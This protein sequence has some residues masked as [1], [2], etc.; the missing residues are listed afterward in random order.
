VVG[1]VRAWLAGNAELPRELILHTLVAVRL[2]C[3]PRRC[4]YAPLYATANGAEAALRQSEE[5]MRLVANNVP[6]IDLVRRPRPALPLQQ[7]HVRRWFGIPHESMQGRT[8][9]EVFGDEA[10]GRMRADIERVPRGASVEFEF[11]SGEGGR[12]ARCRWPA[13]RTSDGERRGARLL[14]AGDDVTALKRAQEDLRYAALQL[15]HDARRLEF[16]AHHD[17]LTGLP[18]RA[19][20]AERAREAVAHARRHGKTARFLFL[21]LDNF[22]RSTTRSAT[23]WATACSRTIASRLRASVRGDDFV[24]RIGGDEFCVLLQ[25]IADPREAA[26]VRRSWCTSSPSPTA[27]ASTSSPRREHRHRLRAAG[28]RGRGDAHAPRRHGHVPRQGA[29]PQRLPVLLADPQQDALG[30]LGHGSG[31]AAPGRCRAASCSSLTSRASTS[32]RIGGRTPRS[33]CAGAIRGHGACSCPSPSCRSPTTTAPGAD[34]RLGAARGLPQGGAG[35]TRLGRSPGVNRHPR[36]LREPPPSRCARRCAKAG[37]PR[38]RCSSRCRR[39]WC[40]R[41]ADRARRARAD[42]RSGARL[43]VDDFGT[44]YAS[45]PDA[46]RRLHASAALDCHRP[47]P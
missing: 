36:Q 28:R 43:G 41:S 45:L 6:R 13:C 7:P 40:A 11:A 21:D 29:R 12:A 14:H 5:R 24:A 19:M 22:K 23:T 3:S 8:V 9:A 42:H 16:L 4:L 30:G 47:Q 35:S 18:N 17:A 38:G 1:G 15:Q 33:C 32:P 27:S 20:F 31:G 37:L 46:C 10:Y 39:P 44:G 26:A 25:D 34:R 2:C